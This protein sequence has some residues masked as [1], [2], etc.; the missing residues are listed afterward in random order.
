MSA[1]QFQIRDIPLFIDVGAQNDGTLNMPIPRIR[2]I[3]RLDFLYQQSRTYSRRDLDTL[4]SRR[5]TFYATLAN[6]PEV[7]LTNLATASITFSG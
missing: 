4:F 6:S 3:L 5:N 1:D 2:R 7:R